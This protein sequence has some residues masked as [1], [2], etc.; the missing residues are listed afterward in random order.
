MDISDIVKAIYELLG[1]SDI[2]LLWAKNL[3]ARALSFFIEM[4]QN[5]T[6]MSKFEKLSTQGFESIKSVLLDINVSVGNIKILK[7]RK[8]VYQV[9]G[10]LLPNAST[11]STSTED[12][13]IKPDNKHNGK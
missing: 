12:Y 8:I 11:V 1:P 13:S 4:Y 2:F 10:P 3:T 6:N 5:P 9:H 7:K